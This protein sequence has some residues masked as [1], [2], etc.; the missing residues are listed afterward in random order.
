MI[1]RLKRNTLIALAFAS[2]VALALTL[3]GRSAPADAQSISVIQGRYQ[4]IDLGRAGDF[5][6]DHIAI[7]DTQ[8][9]VL[10]EWTGKKGGE[11]WT[12]SAADGREVVRR[13]ITV[14]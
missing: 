9:G 11:L 14:R 6:G 2:F 7:F 13:S 5:P 8:T 12:Y 4:F 1:P 10:R 3:T